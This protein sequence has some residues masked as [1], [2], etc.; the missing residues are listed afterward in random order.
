MNE[1]IYFYKLTVDAG[2]APCVSGGLLSLA[3]C[4][5]MIRSSAKE[6]AW[7][8]GFGSDQMSNRLIYIAKITE[9]LTDGKYYCDSRFRKRPDFIYCWNN[10]RLEWRVGAKFHGPDDA[11][12]D[13]GAFPYHRKANVLISDNFR[14][15][16]CNG[17]ADYKDRYRHLAAVIARLR[18]GHRVNHSESIRR[19]LLGLQRE[20]WRRYPG[21]K[22]LGRP[23]HRDRTLRCNA[24]DPSCCS[25]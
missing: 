5:P 12:R 10:D 17:T 20:L 16:G 9:K 1:P 4:K 21:R 23:T 11:S 13:V 7:I 22:V 3:I 24:D 6:G 2:G 25:E 8:F 19:E 18:R 15:L 14:Y